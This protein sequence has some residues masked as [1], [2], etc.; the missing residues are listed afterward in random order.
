MKKLIG[1]FIFLFVGVANAAIISGDFRTEAD[2]PYCCNDAGPVVFQNLG[3]TVGAGAE[4]TADNLL[5]NPSS[6]SGS[7]VSMDLDPLTNIL[8]LTSQDDS[9]FEVFNASISNI[10]FDSG[11]VITGL[12]LISGNLTDLLLAEILSFT[13]NSVSISYD[14]MDSGMQF[15]FNETVAQFQIL[16]SAQPVSAPASL[17]LLGLAVVGLRLAR[18]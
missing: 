9:D 4:L 18:K 7:E 13:D 2:L 5:E 10:L 15:Y 1:V 3:V 16:T 8:S 11:E 12:S 6:W 17:L 14:V